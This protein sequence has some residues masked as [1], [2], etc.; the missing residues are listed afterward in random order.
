MQQHKCDDAS[1][2]FSEFDELYSTQD[3]STCGARAGP[4]GRLGLAVRSWQ[5]PCC[6]TQHDRDV[7]ALVLHPQPRAGLAGTEILRPRGADR[8]YRWVE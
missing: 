4:A 5:C 1:M 2:W 6:G 3:G 8:Q 7:N